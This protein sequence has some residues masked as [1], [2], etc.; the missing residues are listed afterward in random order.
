MYQQTVNAYVAYKNENGIS[1][2]QQ[3][4]RDIDNYND[5]FNIGLNIASPANGY[6]SNKL[7]GNGVILS[8]FMFIT[9]LLQNKENPESYKIGY[10][11]ENIKNGK[12]IL[13]R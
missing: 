2:I 9:G 1:P 12:F 3:R 10:T 8:S 11:N 5:K 6:F 7:G 4:A 13:V